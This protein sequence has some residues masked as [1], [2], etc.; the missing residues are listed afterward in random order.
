MRSKQRALLSVVAIGALAAFLIASCSDDNNNPTN[1]NPNP[2]PTPSTSF[3]G[4]IAG[5]TST[6]LLDVT[7][8]TDTLTAQPGPS[9]MP[10]H[11][12]ATVSATGTVTPDTAAAAA[13]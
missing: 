4:V 7:I 5:P 12:L 13:L 9:V 10:Y 1:P 2:T 11:L 8:A 6:G 3:R